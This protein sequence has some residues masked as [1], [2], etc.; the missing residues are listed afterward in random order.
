[1]K[2]IYPLLL[3][4]LIAPSG[5]H[6]AFA[7]EQGFSGNVALIMG[8]GSD[9]NNLSVEQDA[10][11]N[12]LS[13]EADSESQGIIGVLGT[14]EYTFGEYLN[15]QVYAGTSREDIATGSLA[16]EIGYRQKFESGMIVDFST[17]P[18]VIS[19][20]VW[21]DPYAVGVERKEADLSGN[22][23][24]LKVSN[25]AGSQ[26]GLDMAA[27]KSEVDDEQSGSH[28]TANL[29]P[30]EQ[31]KMVRERDYF[32]LKSDYRFVLDEGMGVV[33]PSL[34]IIHSNAEGNALA[35]NS[36]GG[37]VSYGKKMNRHGLV[38]TLS[39]AARNYE[40]ENPIFK[41][42]RED[43]DMGVFLAYEYEDI[44]GYEDWSAISL[45]GGSKQNSNID[46]YDATQY[47]V[48]VGLDY[49]F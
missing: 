21:A 42:T 36:F 46:F 1:M 23:L 29:T 2:T 7:P 16:F 9:S 33:T 20:E 18:T 25:I 47:I 44:L 5:A 27:G 37:E 17:L 30:E 26:F 4:T 13:S 32:F 28:P 3:A 48:T 35:F 39:A 45:I 43:V 41:K 12:G 11:L 49:K 15:K 22:V 24:R 38:V 31:Q 14:V 8:S 10:R 34:N 6:A 40:E 19:G